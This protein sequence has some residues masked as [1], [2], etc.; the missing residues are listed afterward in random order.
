[1]APKFRDRSI[2][3]IEQVIIAGAAFD[4]VNRT[5]DSITTIVIFSYYKPYTCRETAEEQQDTVPLTYYVPSRLFM[6]AASPICT[7]TVTILV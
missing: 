1:M 3:M 5:I 7:G 4:V 6:H 2:V